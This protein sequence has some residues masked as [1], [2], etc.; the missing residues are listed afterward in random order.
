LPSIQDQ[1]ATT[2]PPSRP[3]TYYVVSPA[4]GHAGAQAGRTDVLTVD[5]A[6]ARDPG[7]ERPLIVRRLLRAVPIVTD[8]T[9]G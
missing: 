4:L 6:T 2:L 7:A 3:R 5:I 9:Q 8:P 1:P